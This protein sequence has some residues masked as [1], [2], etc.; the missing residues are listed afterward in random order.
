MP[1]GQRSRLQ[2]KKYA[3]ELRQQI[4]DKKSRQLQNIV[5]SR[6]EDVKLSQQTTL[7]NSFGGSHASLSKS[8]SPQVPNLSPNS[9][10]SQTDQTAYIPTYTNQKS[11]KPPK[12]VISS[13]PQVESDEQHQIIPISLKET[14]TQST[15]ALELKAQ[16]AEQRKRR[17]LAKQK[18]KEERL[19]EDDITRQYFETQYQKS[20]QNPSSMQTTISS[21]TTTIY[22]AAT[23][24]H[25]I[26][27]SLTTAISPPDLF[28]F[29]K[30]WKHRRRHHHDTKKEEKTQE[31]DDVEE[32]ERLRQV[33]FLLDERRKSKLNEM[34]MQIQQLHSTIPSST[35]DTLQKQILAQQSQTIAEEYGTSQYQPSS[36]LSRSYGPRT[37]KPTVLSPVDHSRRHHYKQPVSSNF[38]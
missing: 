38:D 24:N 33:Q 18:E 1:A 32:I 22:P 3:E 34:N 31:Q 21:L 30:I 23:T 5:N 15:Y 37:S 26:I 16:M 36:L 28:S 19:R 17:M 35:F 2:Q 7:M 29:I 11:T 9:T 10:D 20:H 6:Q 14:A 25:P 8:A 4:A 12:A 27:P 13:H